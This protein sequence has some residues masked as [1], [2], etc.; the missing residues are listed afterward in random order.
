MESNSTIKTPSTIPENIKDYDKLASLF[1]NYRFDHNEITLGI[2]YV[3]LSRPP[4]FELFSVEAEKEA[5]LTVSEMVNLLKFL[6]IR[7]H[8]IILKDLF[9]N[10]CKINTQKTVTLL[11]KMLNRQLPKILTKIINEREEITKRGLM[12]FDRN[13]LINRKNY[14]VK[15]TS[16]KDVIK[17][18][19]FIDNF[20]NLYPKL[21]P[22]KTRSR[23][24]RLGEKAFFCLNTLTML[25]VFH[26]TSLESLYD[27]LTNITETGKGDNVIQEYACIYDCIAIYEQLPPYLDS[28]EKYDNIKNWINS[29]KRAMIRALPVSENRDTFL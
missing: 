21:Y 29:F 14:Q 8:E 18:G 22:P 15:I 23:T 11:I 16:E 20:F 19:D 25:E 1:I 4:L 6:K 5:L 9:N 28:K 12:R 2:L 10:S 24:V 27:N 13:G 3:D 17:W 26:S 7:N